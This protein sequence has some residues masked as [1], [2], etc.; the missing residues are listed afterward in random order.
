M[1]V[2]KIETSNSSREKDEVIQDS[3]NRQRK[4]KTEILEVERKRKNTYRNL[5]FRYDI[6]EA[7]KNGSSLVKKLKEKFK[8]DDTRE[9]ALLSNPQIQELLR[10]ILGEHTT[11]WNKNK[12]NQSKKETEKKDSN[13]QGEE[14]EETE[15]WEDYKERE[16]S[17]ENFEEFLLSDEGIRILVDEIDKHLDNEWNI[18]KNYP[19]S[20]QDLKV[21]LKRSR[22]SVMQR[23]Y[24]E[25]NGISEDNNKLREIEKIGN[26]VA[27]EID[28][29][30]W[31]F[32]KA[33]WD[34][35]DEKLVWNLENLLKDGKNKEIIDKIE[36]DPDLKADFNRAL[37]ESIEKYSKY[38]SVGDK[39][40]LETW[41]K[42]PDLQ[43]RSYL[44]VYWKFF[45]PWLFK[46]NQW[47]Q[48]YERTLPDIMACILAND[49]AKLK[50]LVKNN[51]FWKKEQE[52]EKKRKENDK[53][54]RQAAAKRNKENN[55]NFR[56]GG[57]WDWWKI[58]DRDTV[59]GDINWATWAQIVRQAGFK[60]DDFEHK[61]W[62]IE[63]FANSWFAKQRAFWLAWK[64]FKDN[65]P[66][67][68][69][70][71]TPEDMRKLYNTDSN[72][73]NEE[74]R[75]Q[76]L[77][78]DIMQ[79]RSQEEIDRIHD[80]IKRFP[81]SF[82]EA[83]KRIVSWAR[84]QE[85]WLDEETKNQALWSVID[86]VRFIFADIVEKWK[87]DSK[88]EWFRFDWAN[89]VTREWDNIM[90]YGTFNGSPIKIRYDLISGGLFM[91]SFLQHISPSTI[92]IWN[93]TD[94]DLQIWQLEDFDTIL[95]NHYRAP[96]IAFSRWNQNRW[97]QANPSQ[98][99]WAVQ[100][101]AKWT[102]QWTEQWTDQWLSN[103]EEVVENNTEDKLH[104]ASRHFWRPVWSV[105]EPTPSEPVVTNSPVST[106][107]QSQSF[108][109]WSEIG[110]Q[111][112]GEMEAIRKKYRDMLYANLDMISDRI[113]ENTKKQSARNSVITRFMKTFNI[114]EDG[115]D[116]KGIEFNDWSN[117]FDFIQIIENS[118]PAVLDKFQDFME[119]VSDYSGLNRWRN[120]LFGSQRN[121][122]TETTFDENN[123]NKYISMIRDSAN[124]FS[125]DPNVFK[126]KMNFEPGANLWFVKMIIE[127][128]TDNTSKPNRKL[129]AFKIDD[130]IQHLE[131]DNRV[132]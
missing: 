91:N 116:N 49:D 60:L 83:S 88:F 9:W 46:T 70:I 36:K 101:T 120:N 104:F 12:D 24:D 10:R 97:S 82:N 14:V 17:P 128:I 95:D 15:T 117:L 109:P 103:W 114:I 102:G 42:Q 43:L 123:K 96:E 126:G 66:E 107:S 30:V 124:S 64:S 98:W 122:K 87:W 79:W 39:F 111:N 44:Y 129:D 62:N 31:D 84:R 89:P 41:N 112:I 78:N 47:N 71:I 51:Q 68:E 115:Q 28:T 74:A 22:Y 92:A 40:S 106:W 37:K 61:T 113:V 2:D 56:S 130:F 35:F 38:V 69:E 86:N 55:R 11:E 7:S 34:K 52:D 131:T 121:Q 29:A 57:K 99:Q 26:I 32:L 33:W 125:K 132:S 16:S 77:E 4:L 3:K 76:F 85:A 5:S 18:D 119:K 45:Y 110:K 81:N 6:S 23:E 108:K 63:N 90:I 27:D 50:D 105:E 73:I 1:G 25:K 53:K 13:E 100:W 127:N 67:I 80:I 75:N 59:H 54:R 94:A 93:D 65:Y 21:K 8:D 72:T 20:Y 19:I 48:Y 118:D 58:L